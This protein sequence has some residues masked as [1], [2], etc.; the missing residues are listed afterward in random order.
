MKK[1]SILRELI[2][3]IVVILLAAIMARILSGKINKLIIPSESMEPTIMTGDTVL[4]IHIPKKIKRG[5][6]ATFY[7]PDDDCLYIKRVIGLPYDT[8]TISYGQIYINGNL[9]EEPYI[10]EDW[11]D[12]IYAKDNSAAKGQVYSWTLNE[13][14]YFLMGD[15]RTN[16]HDSRFFGVIKKEKID[17]IMFMNLT[18]V[19]RNFSNK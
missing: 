10:T 12:W 15:N 7:P 11:S 14:E 9:L 2:E 4:T 1:S 19:K 3:I 16:S 17:G 18:E 13:D 5:Q 6:I 8:V